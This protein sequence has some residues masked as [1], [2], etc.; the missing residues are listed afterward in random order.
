LG[1]RASAGGHGVL[2]AGEAA[3]V[4]GVLAAAAGVKG[5]GILAG[6]SRSIYNIVA[7]QNRQ[8]NNLSR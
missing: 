2:A 8:I 5:P 3:W 7:A 6:G 4:Q 1:T